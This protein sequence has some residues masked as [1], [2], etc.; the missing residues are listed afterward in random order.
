MEHIQN[1]NNKKNTS[2]ISKLHKVVLISW[3][4]LLS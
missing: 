3:I 4:I 2:I 1:Y